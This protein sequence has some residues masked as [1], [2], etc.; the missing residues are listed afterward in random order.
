MK[1]RKHGINPVNCCIYLMYHAGFCLLRCQQAAG[2]TGVCNDTDQG[3]VQDECSCCSSARWLTDEDTLRPLIISSLIDWFGP[4][5]FSP[6]FLK[7]LHFKFIS[8]KLLM[9]QPSQI[10]YHSYHADVLQ[11]LIQ[12]KWFHAALKPWP[13]HPWLNLK[14]LHLLGNQQRHFPVFNRP[15]WNKLRSVLCC[16][17]LIC[18]HNSLETQDYL[19]SALPPP[20]CHLRPAWPFSSDLSCEIA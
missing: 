16:W 20:L 4:T 1:R 7:R 19:S 8:L 15:Q 18:W 10:K 2:L 3:S 9:K 11:P 6:F 12:V 17:G 5:F 14:P 13:D